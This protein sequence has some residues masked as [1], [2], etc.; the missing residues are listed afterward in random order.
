MSYPLYQYQDP[1]DDEPPYKP[2]RDASYDSIAEMARRAGDVEIPEP[3][4]VYCSEIEKWA[5]FI[6]NAAAR[7]LDS[8]YGRLKVLASV[9][10]PTFQNQIR[11][12]MSVLLDSLDRLM[13]ATNSS[14]AKPEVE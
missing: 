1:L 3:E 4:P 11:E 13:D 10:S 14:T 2:P 5:T 6:R 9:D 12:P 7:I 8:E